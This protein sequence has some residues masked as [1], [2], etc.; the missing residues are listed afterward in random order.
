MCRRRADGALLM[1]F[2]QQRAL[3]VI[4]A[5]IGMQQKEY[6]AVLDSGSGINVFNLDVLFVE[7]TIKRVTPLCITNSSEPY[8][9]V[10]EKGDVY[11]LE[12]MEVYLDRKIFI[13]VI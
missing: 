9:R 3:H 5:A 8:R 6:M 4:F 7:G 2:S 13:N 10:N 12:N 1:T 11:G